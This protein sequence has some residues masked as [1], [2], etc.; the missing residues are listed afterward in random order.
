[1]TRQKFSVK[2]TETEIVWYVELQNVH[3]VMRT[4]IHCQKKD[5]IFVNYEDPEGIKRF[6]RLW[7][8]GNGSGTVWIYR[9]DS[10]NL[11]LID[12]LIVGHVG[13]E[14]GEFDS[15]ANAD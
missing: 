1:M 12:E 9:K 7:N 6:S 14:Y 5:M 13:C 8:G 4:E 2:E 10:G 15:D 11:I 3:S